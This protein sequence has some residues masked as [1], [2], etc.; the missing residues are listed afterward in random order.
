M[1]GAAKPSVLVP[2]PTCDASGNS[3]SKA[4]LK[5]VTGALSLISS[6]LSSPVEVTAGMCLVPVDGADSKANPFSRLKS[7]VCQ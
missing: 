1:G 4:Q 7:D 5:V 3:T 6:S 2:A